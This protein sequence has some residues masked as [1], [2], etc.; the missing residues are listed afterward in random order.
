MNHPPSIDNPKYDYN[1]KNGAVKIGQL[2]DIDLSPAVTEP[3]GQEWQVIDVRSYT[4]TAAA[5][6]PNSVTNK[7]IRF[8]A[9][10]VGEHIISYIVADHYGGYSA[11]LIKVT[12]SESEQAN[13]W[14]SLKTGGTT[15]SAPLRYSD[16]VNSGFAVSAVWDDGVGNTLSGYT[17][18]SANAYCYNLGFMPTLEQMQLLRSAHYQD[19][20]SG[21]LNKWP[22]MKPYLIKSG[23]DYLGYDVTTGK[24][25]AYSPQASYYVTCAINNDIR[26]IVLTREVV[27]DGEEKVIGRV[28]NPLSQE[29]K[30]EKAE[31]T[32][33]DA[34]DNVFLQLRAEDSG[35]KVQEITTSSI[36]A[37]TYRFK[38]VNQSDNTDDEL[39]SPVIT[40]I[41]DITNPALNKDDGSIDS[42][43]ADDAAE[44]SATFTLKD[45]NDNPLANQEVDVTW[46]ANTL[47]EVTMTAPINQTLKGSEITIKGVTNSAG[48]LSVSAMSGNALDNITVTVK[49]NHV[50]ASW[51]PIFTSLLPNT[52]D[53]VRVGNLMFARPRLS[54]EAAKLNVPYG[55]QSETGEKGP[56]GDWATYKGV[57]MSSLCNAYNDKN[58][59]GRSN[60]RVPTNIELQGLQR[61]V[62]NAFNTQ[63]W[64]TSLAYLSNKDAYTNNGYP[65][66]VTAWLDGRAAMPVVGV[67]GYRYLSCVTKEL[68]GP[69]IDTVGVNTTNGLYS[70]VDEVG[71]GMLYTSSPSVDYLKH[72]G[73]AYTSYHSDSGVAGT[74]G[75]L[76][77]EQA[78]NLCTIYNKN[79]LWGR[80]NWRLARVGE[81]NYLKL[82][83]DPK[84]SN[85]FMSSEHGWP[86]DGE[87][88]AVRMNNG[89][90]EYFYIVHNP[91]YP[92]GPWEDTS[93]H[94]GYKAT[95]VSPQ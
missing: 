15:Y 23:T 56:E 17:G 54:S 95:C 76:N 63:G 68:A 58:Y 79:K 64:P 44:V 78:L 77:R 2:I 29:L 90:P 53:F 49:Y 73:A 87:S 88:R 84:N 45:L 13:T 70:L 4:A 34:L 20:K 9:A 31:N 62:S 83:Y 48:K 94:L 36:N 38:L 51:N 37:G 71:A 11:G 91:W 86:W 3:D 60:W 12:A 1:A 5:K 8:Q 40:Y 25:N 82:Y 32:R 22:A 80:S 6:D 55:G 35:R 81:I 39:T 27:A 24:T 61:T 50:E 57:D 85:K 67:N 74:Y 14:T 75:G 16:G 92:A 43:V 28:E 26:L 69:Y 33:P 52:T 72:I 47:D 18:I 41:G 89:V 30:I 66:Y 65:G 21:E 59:N 10:T 19:D 7:V 46:Q 93:P 42:A